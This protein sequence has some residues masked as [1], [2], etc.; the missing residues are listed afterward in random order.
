MNGGM[1]CSAKVVP[2]Q[3]LKQFNVPS[4]TLYS[5]DEI[6]RSF[7]RFIVLSAALFLYGNLGLNVR[8]LSWILL[9]KLENTVT[10]ADV[11]VATKR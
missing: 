3:I 2:N 7:L 4:V 8:A 5:D 9:Q 6:K 1:L 10:K 11:T